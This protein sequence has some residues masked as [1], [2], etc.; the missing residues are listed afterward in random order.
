VKREV[1]QSNERVE[2]GCP[3]AQDGIGD[4]R[5]LQIER[6][7]A[8]SNSQISIDQNIISKVGNGSQ[9]PQKESKCKGNS[10]WSG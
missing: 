7:I 8:Q 6:A 1:A 4:L 5:V 2:M 10:C 3:P 9:G